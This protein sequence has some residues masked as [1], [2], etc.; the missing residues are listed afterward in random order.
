MR[1]QITTDTGTITVEVEVSD[2]ARRTLFTKLRSRWLACPDAGDDD[3]V[4][5]RPEQLA[6]ADEVADLLGDYCAEYL[7]ECEQVWHTSSAF[8]DVEKQMRDLDKRA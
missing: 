5:T 6:T 1:L 8:A 2:A 7:A 4:W 3:T